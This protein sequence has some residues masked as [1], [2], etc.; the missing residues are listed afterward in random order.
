[1]LY[2]SLSSKSPCAAPLLTICSVY[3]PWA[4]PMSL[5]RNMKIF[6]APTE[7]GANVES[8][9]ELKTLAQ[10]KTTL[11]MAVYELHQGVITIRKQNPTTGEVENTSLHGSIC[12][13]R[14]AYLDN[15]SR[16]KWTMQASH[17]LACHFWDSCKGKDTM[18]CAK[19]D[20]EQLSSP[21]RVAF[22]EPSSF[23]GSPIHLSSRESLGL[24]GYTSGRDARQCIRKLLRIALYECFD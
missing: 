7:S 23:N 10:D 22:I 1:M 20:Q 3:G 2:E 13:W 8:C 9:M 24:S 21:Q 14:I 5:F 19:S 16:A 6:A 15:E 18:H 17:A 4:P 11:R 12:R